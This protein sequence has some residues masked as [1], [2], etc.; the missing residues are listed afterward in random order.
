MINCA[1]CDSGDDDGDNDDDDDDGDDNGDDDCV[2]QEVLNRQ[3][4]QLSGFG[5]IILKRIWNFL[6]ALI[7]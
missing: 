5:L 2:R 6:I 3:K 1:Y 7:R 4:V